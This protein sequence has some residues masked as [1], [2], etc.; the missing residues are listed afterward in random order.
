MTKLISALIAATSLPLA[1]W[2]FT[3]RVPLQISKQHSLASGN[4]RVL[5]STPTSSE[6]TASKPIIDNV[7]SKAF[8]EDDTSH[9]LGKAIPYDEL[10]IGVLKESMD[11]ETRVSQTPD[12]VA[13]LV[14]AGFHVLVE[15]GG[16]CV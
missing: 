6:D 8:E 5:F 3:P 14:K 10:T 11:G 4:N 2:S 1:C 16:M 13:N 12:S 15:A 7:I 9:F